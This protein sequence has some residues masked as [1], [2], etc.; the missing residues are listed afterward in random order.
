MER[1]LRRLLAQFAIVA[2]IV[3]GTATIA[4]P[5]HATAA[6]CRAYFAAWYEVG[7]NL[8]KAC[9]IAGEGDVERCVD[10]IS[11]LYDYIPGDR[12][13]NGCTIGGR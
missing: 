1:L 5:A 8:S 9:E 2:A 11:D 6:Q 7:P 4:T 3:A 13:R 10:L 12:V